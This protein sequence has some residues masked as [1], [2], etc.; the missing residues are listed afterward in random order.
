MMEREKVIKGLESFK[1]DLKPFAGN[2]AD[3]AK[4]DNA[5]AL[6]KAQEPRTAY[7]IR[8][9]GKS[10]TWYCSHCGEKINYNN[11]HRVYKKGMKPIEQVNR[12]CRGCG[13]TMTSRPTDAQREAAKA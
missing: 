5:I 13:Y 7:W 3:W 11:A 12:F 1:A 6:L 8:G 10:H 9:E 2:H 4:V